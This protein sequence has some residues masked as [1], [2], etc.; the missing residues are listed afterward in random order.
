MRYR[1]VGSNGS[2][3][4]VKLR[5]IMRYRRLPFDWVLRT[6]AV[7][8]EMA[9]LKVQLVPALR[10]PE[11][12]RYLLDSTPIAYALER[13]H[14]DGRGIVPEDPGLAFLSHLIED[15]ADEW[16]T[17]AMFLYRWEAP[18]DQAYC[19]R[20]IIAD[21]RPDLSG[22]AFEEA[23]RGIRDRQVGRMPLVGCTPENAPVIKES[24]RRVLAILE[25]HVGHGRFLFGSRPALADFGLFGQLKTL[26]TDPTP[27]RLIQT[28]AP[29]V[30]H[31]LRQLDDASGME[32]SWIDPAAP[33][34]AAVIDLLEH[35]GEVYLPF[36]LANARAAD[37]GEARFALD[38][39]GGRYEQAP[40]GYQA[41]CLQW[42]R[43]EYAA[44]EGEPARRVRDVLGA[45]GCLA[46]FG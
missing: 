14:P 33:L 26:D 43:D 34:P 21:S 12:G 19:S 37:A 29:M 42:L 28:T 2:P 23:V 16:V 5:S 20:W 27:A 4:S 30:E 25:G 15:M 24:L 22:E 41:K 44:L 32:G 7:R 39:P 45:T 1:L 40:F 3:Y 18:E 17:K 13:R 46:A 35:A 31:W 38:L 10:L 8:A 36:L 6:P 11:D 9:G